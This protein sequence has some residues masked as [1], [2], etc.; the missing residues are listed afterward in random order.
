MK[1]QPRS[2]HSHQ[3]R[4]NRFLAVTALVLS[5]PI[6]ARAT[7]VTL[8]LSS[9]PTGTFTSGLSVDGFTLT[10]NLGPSS[11]PMIVDAGGVYALESSGDVELGADTLLTLNGGGTFTLDSIEVAAL[12]GDTGHFTIGIGAAPSGLGYVYGEGC[13]NEPQ[14]VC[15]GPLSSTFTTEN[16][17]GV[18]GFENV[19]L[20]DL[21]PVEGGDGDAIAAVTV[22]FGSD[23]SVPEP[24]SIM[25]LAMGTAATAALRRRRRSKQVSATTDA[26]L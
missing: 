13:S 15:G 10:P 26:V 11:I 19:T 12:N 6:A 17:A 24:A 1:G 8:D 16:Y 3:A 23:T 5:L 21:D 9:L 4:I 14:F 18:S 20:I 22:T 2:M 25:L 7:T